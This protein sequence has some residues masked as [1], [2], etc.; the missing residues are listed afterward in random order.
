MFIESNRNK[1]MVGYFK[2]L[3]MSGIENILL[4]NCVNYFS[5]LQKYY[6]AIV[7]S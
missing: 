3:G 5:L 6:V 4:N 7:K 1:F 2:K